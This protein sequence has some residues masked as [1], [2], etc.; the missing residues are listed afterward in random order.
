[1]LWIDSSVDPNVLKVWKLGEWVK[2]NLSIEELDPEFSGI[3]DD[4]KEFTIKA[5]SDGVI[6]SGEKLNVK[7]LLVELTGSPMT[8]SMPTITQID[9]SKSGQVY[10][11]RA[12]SLA[13]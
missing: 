6:T 11:A 3:V 2:Q 12:G 9:N 4:L 5:A 10:Q 13:A 8:T 1:T 7:L